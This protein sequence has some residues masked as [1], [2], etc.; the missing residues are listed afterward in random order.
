MILR[1]LP[2]IRAPLLLA[3]ATPVLLTAC[4]LP[5]KEVIKEKAAARKAWRAQEKQRKTL[6]KDIP[7]QVARVSEGRKSAPM[8][9]ANRLTISVSVPDNDTI[10]I[11]GAN[12][13]PPVAAKAMVPAERIVAPTSTA[14]T[15]TADVTLAKTKKGKDTPAVPSRQMAQLTPVDGVAATHPY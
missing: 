3:L 6:R 4:W 1:R 2:L 12:P 5:P 9:A 11:A 7:E 15:S 14:P 10:E 8:V 13:P